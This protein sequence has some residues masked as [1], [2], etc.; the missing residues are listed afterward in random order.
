MQQNSSKKSNKKTPRRPVTPGKSKNGKELWMKALKKRQTL[1]MSNAYRP[2]TPRHKTST[3]YF[4]ESLRKSGVGMR[5]E[6][7]LTGLPRANN[8]LMPY[9]STPHYLRQFMGTEKIGRN[10]DLTARPNVGTP[11][12]K[13]P[14]EYY[15]EVLELRK[16]ISGL[17]LESSTN[18]TKIRRLEEENQKKEKEIE[19]LLNPGKNGEIRRTMADKNAD[20]GA[21]I[22]NYKQKIL[23]LEM[24]LKDKEAAYSKLQGDLKTTKIEEMRVQLEAVY[25]EVI[26][27]QMTKDSDKTSSTK[28]SA[29]KVK[30][31]SETVIRLSKTNEQ[32]QI[33]NKSLKED[34]HRAMED[35]EKAQSD[36]ANM[37]KRDQTSY[38]DKRVS[39]RGRGERDQLSSRSRH[40]GK[41][42]LKG[43]LEE[44]LHQ[45][46][47]RETELL[48]QIDD[49]KATLQRNLQEKQKKESMSS[50]PPTPRRRQSSA[51]HFQSEDVVDGRLYSEPGS[52]P[53]SSRSK[54]SE[55]ENFK[56]K[57]AAKNIQRQW[58]Q[59][60]QHQVDHQMDDE[61]EAFKENLAAK[62]I[63]RGWLD[64]KQHKY[65]EE[66]DDAAYMIQGSLKAHHTRKKQMNQWSF[67]YRDVDEED[68]DDEDIDLIQSTFR[69][70]KARKQ[71][72]GNLKN[73]LSRREESKSAGSVRSLSHQSLSGARGS[74]SRDPSPMGSQILGDS[75]SRRPSSASYKSKR[76]SV[77][78]VFKAKYNVQPSNDDDDDIMF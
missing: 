12:Y 60:K 74:A 18:K 69:G 15:D 2:T 64:H 75:L 5:R 20:S 31:L 50:L 11:A 27:L 49:L 39:D 66:L 41:I 45:L 25:G 22:H 7:T 38:T 23:K 29:A 59:H 30:A 48:Q 78:Q 10:D 76:G 70:H 56:Q 14:E 52:R 72:L 73:M 13:T 36:F 40:Q 3:E 51:N 33:E 9:M 61:V 44:R 19:A 42:D 4:I 28:E 43:S 47:Q 21:V 1:T 71:E 37:K 54:S 46:D 26:R 55:V 6:T 8:E 16:Q 53:S 34:L 68:D 63:Q 24:Q 58:R 32:L 57:H 62:R 17:A 65:N 35:S 67:K 77:S